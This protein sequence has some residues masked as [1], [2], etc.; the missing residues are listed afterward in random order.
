[1]LSV[2]KINVKKISR[3]SEKIE[4]L[5]I[6][7]FKNHKIKEILKK[8]NN[9]DQELLISAITV[10]SFNGSIGK[11]LLVYGKNNIKRIFKIWW[12]ICE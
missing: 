5:Y 11:T 8:L 4:I 6:P 3:I 1:M 10:E 12:N 9:S 7:I 2:K